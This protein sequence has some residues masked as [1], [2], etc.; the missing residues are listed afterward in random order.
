MVVFLQCNHF[1]PY[2]GL[3]FA[4]YELNKP[5]L[6]FSTFFTGRPGGEGGQGLSDNAGQTGEGV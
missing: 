6:Q 4:I 3:Y 2:I 1:S 5:F